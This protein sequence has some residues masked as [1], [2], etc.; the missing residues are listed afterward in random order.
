MET[1]PSLGCYHVQ[2]LSETIGALTNLTEFEV[3]EIFRLTL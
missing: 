1:Y 3:V 2:D